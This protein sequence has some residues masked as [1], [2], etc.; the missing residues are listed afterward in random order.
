MVCCARLSRTQERTYRGVAR[1][2]SP[3]CSIFGDESSQLTLDRWEGRIR[4]GQRLQRMPDLMRQEQKVR[5]PPRAGARD[6]GFAIT[7]VVQGKGAFSPGVPGL[8]DAGSMRATATSATLLLVHT[9][10]SPMRIPVLI[11]R[12]LTGVAPKALV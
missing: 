5:G 12:N 2:E 4:C 9:S 3:P 10:L 11:R 7:H 1:R 8:T 6:E